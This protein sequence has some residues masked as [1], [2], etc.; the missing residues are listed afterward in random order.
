MGDRKQQSVQGIVEDWRLRVAG[1][2]V[3]GKQKGS[4]RPISSSPKTPTGKC[5][6]HDFPK[7]HREPIQEFLSV[8]TRPLKP[9]SSPAPS[10]ADIYQTGN[11]VPPWWWFMTCILEP[12]WPIKCQERGL[13]F[14]SDFPKAH[15]GI[16]KMAPV[17]P[18]VKQFKDI[19]F[20][21]T[22]SS[23]EKL[24]TTFKKHRQVHFPFS[25]SPHA[26]L[27]R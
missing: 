26:T 9:T 17:Y 2:Q 20:D 10:H 8:F 19:S 16:F 21:I 13:K 12:L 3:G 5:K 15:C 4:E 25:D 24:Q 1:R 6:T 27:T 11:A 14:P 22:W 23:R 7:T 18:T